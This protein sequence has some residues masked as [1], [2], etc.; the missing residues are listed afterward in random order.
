M[1]KKNS[2]KETFFAPFIL[3]YRYAAIYYGQTQII[4]IQSMYTHT[5]THKN[6]QSHTHTHPHTHTL[7]HSHTH[8]TFSLSL[9]YKY[10]PYWY[11]LSNLSHLAKL[12]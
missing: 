10:L 4:N 2:K 1:L 11:F 6:T 5:H 7:T 8:S 12:K 9:Q 3:K